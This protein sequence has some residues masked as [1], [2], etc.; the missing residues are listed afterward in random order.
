MKDMPNIHLKKAGVFLITVDGEEKIAARIKFH[1]IGE[2]VDGT[3]VVEVR[4]VDCDGKKRTAIFDLS[5]LNPRN[6]NAVADGLANKG[7]LWPTSGPSPV[8]ILKAV[9]A[10]IP[11]RRFRF[12]GA[13][14]YH[15]GALVT[16]LRQY[17][18][19]TKIV[20]D[21]NSGAHL[22]NYTM[23][24]GSLESWQ[25]TVGNRAK[26]STR[27]RLAIA[28]AFAAPFLR[29]LFMDSFA[30]NLF[31]PTST[32]KTSLLCG[33]ASVPGLIS[34]AKG[35]P[36]W[37]DSDAGIE[38]LAIGH[39]DGLMLLDE[40]GDEDGNVP[41]HKKAQRLAYL[42]SRNRAKILNK[43]YLKTINLTDRD[44]RVI[45]ISTSETALK[46]IA[47]AAGQSRKGGEEIR[48]IDVP[49]TELGSIGIFDCVDTPKDR[50][51]SEFGRTLADQLR[52]DS[53][54]NQGF[55][56]DAFLKKFMNAPEEALAKVKQRMAD[57][58]AKTSTTL[59]T[60]ADHRVLAN[61]AL[62]YAAATLAIDYE[63]LPWKREPTRKALEKCMDAA[64]TKIRESFTQL[65]TIGPDIHDLAAKLKSN[66]DQLSILVIEK[67]SRCGEKEAHKRQAADAFRVGKE[68][69]VKSK[70]W[71]GFS[72]IETKELVAQKILKTEKRADVSTMSKQIAGIDK[73]LRY[74]IV[75]EARLTQLRLQDERSGVGS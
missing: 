73:K 62:M 51:P 72:S 59:T 18:G 8:D 20:I 14:G 64:F 61:F 19:K 43:S 27:L 24:S 33:A 28:A 29:P 66:L 47:G 60:G 50:T 42:F 40:S 7:Y 49:A 63:I 6:L 39:R 71:S 75:D 26:S 48:F 15:E 46:D 70:R 34:E 36:K 56:I 17:G 23:G 67:G 22:A 44:F 55:A 31:G 68:L 53:A 4:F 16:P 58:T 21:Q 3:K 13:P 1:A 41:A 37:A 54:T 69:Y 9:V 52:R 65:V 45:V 11:G 74:Y 30:I 57:F 38:Q 10:K 25:K 12:V 5:A 35:L 32:G 2:R